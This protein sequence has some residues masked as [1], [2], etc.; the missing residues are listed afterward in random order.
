MT[1]RIVPQLPRFVGA[2]V[3]CFSV[4]S[5]PALAQNYMPVRLIPTK[6]SKYLPAPIGLE[7]GSTPATPVVSSH[8]VHAPILPPVTAWNLPASYS[9][10]AHRSILGN[11]VRVSETP[12][13]QQ[14]QMAVGSFLHGRMR[15]D[16]LGTVTVMESLLRGLPGS[17]SHPSRSATPLGHTDMSA[18]SVN[19]TYGFSLSLHHAGIEDGPSALRIARHLGTLFRRG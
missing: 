19:N 6:D 16:G 7:G 13:D 2:V 8:L 9:N 18:P 4:F 12:F 10:P 5:F 15:L 17:G 14:F 3:L 1:G 11:A